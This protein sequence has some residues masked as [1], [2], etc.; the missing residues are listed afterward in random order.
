MDLRQ[1]SR[2]DLY[3]ANSRASSD[4]T[5]FIKVDSLLST[6]KKFHSNAKQIVSGDRDYQKNKFYNDKKCNELISSISYLPKNRIKFTPLNLMSYPSPN[7]FSI[8]NKHNSRSDKIE[9]SLMPFQMGNKNETSSNGTNYM[10]SG[11]ENEF[12]TFKT[13]FILKFA[14]NV[15]V[16][17]KVNKYLDIIS[18]SNKKNIFDY[19][20]RIRTCTDK[21]DQILFDSM[22][23]NILTENNKNNESNSNKANSNYK[24]WKECTIL[25]YEFEVF[26]LKL[27]DIILKELKSAKDS[28]ILLAKKNS[29]Q[30]NI[31]SQREKEVSELN[32]LIETHDIYNK[33]QKAK[34]KNSELNEIKEEYNR[35]DKIN[36]FNVYRLEEE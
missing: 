28:N 15:E 13:N 21:K 29:D 6:K 26:W 16:Y 23:Y 11:S 34:K 27:S 31:I 3:S 19:F 12:L 32:E 18:D 4:L 36:V 17:D 30:T 1:D 9:D 25:F 20:R 8:G 33:T 14:K 5:S 10:M 7:K 24:H 22:N 2:R 35:K